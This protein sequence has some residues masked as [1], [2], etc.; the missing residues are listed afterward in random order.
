MP[1]PAVIP[2]PIVYFKVVAV[3]TLVVNLRMNDKCSLIFYRYY[4][5]I[6]YLVW[7]VFIEVLISDLNFF[8]VLYKSFESG[9]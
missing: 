8:E 6:I 4:L 5:D 1:A 9:D 3:K 7:K 2:A